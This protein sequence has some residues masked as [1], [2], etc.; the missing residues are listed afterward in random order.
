MEIHYIVHARVDDLSYG[1]FLKASREQSSRMEVSGDA[2]LNAFTHIPD[3]SSAED[4]VAAAAATPNSSEE[5]KR[6]LDPLEEE[7]PLDTVRNIRRRLAL[8][9]APK[10]AGVSG[11]S[12]V[13]EGEL[14]EW[15]R[16]VVINNVDLAE[17]LRST[18]P[19]GNRRA[20]ARVLYRAQVKPRGANGVRASAFAGSLR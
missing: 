4:L 11:V 6:C 1:Y 15:T 18:K 8:G 9:P 19:R 20:W 16:K 14:T 3:V 13:D 7:D 5:R 2:Y 12:L 17:M 10:D